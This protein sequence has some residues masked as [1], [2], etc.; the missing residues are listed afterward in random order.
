MNDIKLYFNY[1]KGLPLEHFKSTGEALPSSY[2]IYWCMMATFIHRIF[3]KED[4]KEFL[5]RM[6]V[7][8][9]S[10]NLVENWLIDDGLIN[11]SVND[12]LYALSLDDIIMHMGFEAVDGCENWS[13]REFYLDNV[14]RGISNA[15]FF[16]GLGDFLVINPVLDGLDSIDLSGKRF[17]PEITPE[18]IAKADFFAN[19]IMRFIPEKIFDQ[20]SKTL[21]EKEEELALRKEKVRNI[22]IFEIDKIPDE[23]IR[24]CLEIMFRIDFVEELLVSPVKFN[25]TARPLIYLA[26]LWANDFLHRDHEGCVNER[27]GIILNYDDYELEDGGSNLLITIEDYNLE[28]TVP[29]LKGLLF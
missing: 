23:I 14:A 15:M 8:L 3:T 5:F 21:L 9:H 17:T 2:A 29:L 11:Y 7:S 24:Q 19:D 18:L 22:P 4:M 6:A 28:E 27:E 10:R 26:W 13:S 12:Q 20:R 1:V 25:A 16:G